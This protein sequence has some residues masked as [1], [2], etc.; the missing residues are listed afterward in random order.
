LISMEFVMRHA[1]VTKEA[2]SVSSEPALGFGAMAGL[3]LDLPIT[4]FMSI[5]LGGD[6]RYV[7]DAFSSR[8]EFSTAVVGGF[9]FAI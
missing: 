3:G 7:Q 9:G 4:S 6:A 2:T 5:W 8:F 1:F